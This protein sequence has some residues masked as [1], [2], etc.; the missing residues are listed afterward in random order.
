MKDIKINGCRTDLQ[1]FFDNSLKYDIN[2]KLNHTPFIV[3][4]EENNSLDIVHKVSTLLENFGDKPETKVIIQWK[5][6]WNS[7]FFTF[8]V[9]ELQI[10]VDLYKLQNE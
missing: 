4:N 7:D 5:G 9:G 10:E 8:T 3:V 1:N 2:V 6:Q